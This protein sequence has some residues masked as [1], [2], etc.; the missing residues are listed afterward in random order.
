VVPGRLRHLIAAAAA[1]MLA[2]VSV[3]PAALSAD[4][5][6]PASAA[7]TARAAGSDGRFE[8][9]STVDP[10]QPMRWLACRPIDYR[11]NPTDM[12]AG[13]ATTVRS[14]MRVL[15]TQTGVRFRDAGRTAHTFAATSHDATPTIYF[16]FTRR[17]R[18]A[19]QTFGGAG[20]EIGAGGPA[21]A[22]SGSG[23]DTVEAMTYG[24]VLLSSRFR[25]PRTGRG[26]TWQAL[27]LHEVGH[28]LN[29]AH[30]DDPASIMHPTLTAATPAR[31]TPQEVRALRQ[32]LRTTGCDC[33][34]WSRL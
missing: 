10:T 24:R 14:A 4:H 15:Q 16:A 5:V 29:L 34:A 8:M 22:W 19:G 7:R 3:A 26:V 9:R 27:I 12:P 30:S 23:P 1:L 18:A 17:A 32:V 2:A 21:A 28:A 25:A 31:F 20:G 6:E 33:A 13:M 11:I